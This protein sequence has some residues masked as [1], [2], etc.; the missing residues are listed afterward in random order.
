MLLDTQ[1]IVQLLLS[2]ENEFDKNLDY[3]STNSPDRGESLSSLFK[4]PEHLREI[5]R[6][7]D[8]DR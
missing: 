6:E 1:F 8:F 7:N 3:L 5:I 4:D 2:S